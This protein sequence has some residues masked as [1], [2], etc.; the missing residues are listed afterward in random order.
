MD[1]TICTM[2]ESVANNGEGILW[3]INSGETMCHREN[4]RRKKRSTLGKLQA[5]A[6]L[7]FFV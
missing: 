4:G 7:Q 6:T 3:Q 2:W 5:I 1:S